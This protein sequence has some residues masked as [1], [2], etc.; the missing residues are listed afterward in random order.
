MIYR[1]S[2]T[3]VDQRIRDLHAEGHTTA[4]IVARVHRSHDV[5]R[6]RLAAMGLKEHVKIG[7]RHAQPWRRE[8]SL[9]P[10]GIHSAPFTDGWYAQNQANFVRGMQRVL[11]REAGQ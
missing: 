7:D 2:H 10:K 1:R 5:V 9:I 3:E 8:R 6:Q 11:G 4:G